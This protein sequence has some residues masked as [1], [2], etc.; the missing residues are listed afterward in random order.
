MKKLALVVVVCLVALSG[1]IYINN[2]RL[3]IKGSGVVIKE[4]RDVAS[5]DALALGGSYDIAIKF[6]DVQS[7]VLEGDDN[8]LPLIKTDVSQ[9]RL[10]INYIESYSTAQRVKLIITVV[11]LERLTLS[12]SARGVI[13]NINNEMFAL[14][15]SGSDKLTLDGNT[16]QFRVNISGSGKIDAHALN[17]HD[18]ALHLSGSGKMI[19]TALEKLDVKVSGSGDVVFYGHPAAVTQSV[20]G[21]GA[22]RSGK[23]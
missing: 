13:Q 9:G 19:V 10:K 5:F 4:T 17:A 14:K 16:D 3:N 6:G 15:I 22:I 11:K 18:V 23:S 21:S 20:S 7:V 1:C 2:G 12:G 8:I